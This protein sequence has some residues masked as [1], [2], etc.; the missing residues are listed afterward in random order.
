MAA[1]SSITMI[2]DLALILCSAGV[3]TLIFKKLKQPVVLGYIIAGFLVSPHVHFFPSIIGDGIEDV[4]A[5][6]EISDNIKVWSEIGVIFLLFTLGL[7]FSFK[8]L[9]KVGGPA[10]IT[11][12]LGVVS[13][14]F[15]GYFVG[16]LM[17]WPWM[18]SIFLGAILSISSTSIVVKALEEL[19]LKNRKFAHLVFGTLIIEDLIAILLMVLLSTMAVSRNI[20]E[21]QLLFSLI[22]LLF[23]LILWF[24]AGIFLIPS[25]LR[26]TKKLMNDETLLIV[27][28]GLCFAMV[29][30][31]EEV[32]FSQALGAFIMGSILA[33]TMSAERIE[34]LVKPVRDLFGAIFFVSVGMMI[35]PEKIAEH[36]MPILIVT[37]ITIFG[38]A[39]STFIGALISGIPLRQTVYA[40]MSRTQ[41]G[42]FSFII[43]QLG[44]TLKVTS[45][46]LY[47]IT[48]A[49]SAITTFT[50]PFLIRL[51]EPLYN[52]IER[53]TPA[54]WIANYNRYSTGAQRINA[55]SEWQT[56]IRSF[57]LITIINTVVIVGIIILFSA[58]IGPAVFGDDE[59]L[60]WQKL[61]ITL[62]TLIFIAPF[63]WALTARKMGKNAYTTLWLNKYNRGPILMLEFVRIVIAIMLV[64][65]LLDQFFSTLTALILAATIIVISFIIFS[66]K[67][68][69]Y[70][71]RIEERFMTNFNAREMKESTTKIDKL[72]PWDAHIA[73]FEV[74]THSF[75]VGKSLKDAQLREQFGINIA[76]ILRGETKIPLP[77]RDEIIYPLDKIAVIGTDDQLLN[78]KTRLE[79]AADMTAT[80]EV[81]S[82][83]IDLIPFVVK[84][85]F[86]F[87]GLSIRES[88]IREKTKG[89]IVGIERNGERILNPDSAM[90]F[91]LD[92]TVWIVGNK[93][94]IKSVIAFKDPIGH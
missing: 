15:L 42:E 12:F 32:G 66:R 14:L 83:A 53:K 94:R 45:E 60:F 29:M 90:I 93:K 86:P 2:H 41:I 82:D 54:S 27:S 24:A 49:V 40:S 36:A 84:P 71:A 64:G 81:V 38:K 18:D 59:F 62:A 9:V 69:S 16:Q 72:S 21:G 63:V 30:L 85:G 92:D 67:L 47:P 79:E 10:S 35:D 25:F 50:T 77:N 76:M 3:T 78:F 46:F 52:F 19:G 73:Y 43:A 56:L 1:H 31:A 57:L 65:F 91:Q 55:G 51:S 6:G 58:V 13:M 89:L 37:L 39:G 61:V 33:E 74:P 88:S 28:I 22:K 20:E 70:S 87:I 34:H 23:F 5:N 26:V 80:R 68:Q 48:I 4:N 17:G 8:K 75:V 11:T 7:E 44:L